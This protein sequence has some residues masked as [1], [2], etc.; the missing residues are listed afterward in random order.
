MLAFATW[1]EYTKY[2]AGTVPVNRVYLAAAFAAM[3]IYFG[4]SSFWRARKKRQ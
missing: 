1:R 2:R 4:L 3:F